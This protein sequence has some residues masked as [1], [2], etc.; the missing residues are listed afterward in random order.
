MESEGI[1]NKTTLKKYKATCPVCKRSHESDN[2][3]ASILDLKHHPECDE[4]KGIPIKYDIEDS[5]F[6]E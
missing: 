6:A 5:R 1:R 2:L 4:R 3:N